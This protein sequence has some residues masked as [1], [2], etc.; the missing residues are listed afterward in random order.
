MDKTENTA[1]VAACALMALFFAALVYAAIALDIDVPTCVT[2][3]APFTK[4]EII[5]KG[6]NHYEVHM[7][8]KMWAFDPEELRLPPGA[9][10]DLYLSSLDVTH[11]LYVEGTNVNLM[12]VPGAVNSARF[13]IDE[14]GEHAVICHEYCGIAHEHM[15]G[16]I[17]VA[18]GASPLV[19]A[20][21]APAEAGSGAVLF[22]RSGCDVCHSI[23]GSESIAPTMK[24][25]Y[26][27]VVRF[28][29]GGSLRAD[30][31]YIAESIRS[32]GAHIVAGYEDL[33]P[34]NTLSDED[35]RRLVDYIRELP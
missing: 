32:P 15:V 28:T 29:D 33:M 25:L 7:V 17:V 1:L 26:G 10:V 16:K 8:A 4:P 24:G 23:D 12:A 27:R 20:G 3:V 13:R 2:D 14:E 5:D 21:T 30:D 22:A 18:E 9:Q 11:G 31:A 19:P 6:G 35:V 34:P